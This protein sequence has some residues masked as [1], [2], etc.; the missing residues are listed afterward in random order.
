MSMVTEVQQCLHTESM[1]NILIRDVPPGLHRRL[2][3]LAKSRG[4]SLQQFLVTELAHLAERPTMDE[5]LDR[6]ER[7]K[8]GRVGL[9]WAADYL[10][11]DRMSH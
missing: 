2:Q 6:V 4:Q 11:K 9:K 1:P 3:A 7:R 10:A 8:G 5:L